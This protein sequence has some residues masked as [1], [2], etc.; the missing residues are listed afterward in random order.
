VS[1]R[2][3]LIHIQSEFGYQTPRRNPINARNR[4]QPGDI[5]TERECVAL[6][7]SSTRSI[8][9]PRVAI[10]HQLCQHERGAQ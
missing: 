9:A 7:L 2:R 6:D 4:A 3:E 1:R 5:I 8:L 10:I